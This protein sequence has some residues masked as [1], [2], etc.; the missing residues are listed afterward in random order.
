[1]K[2]LPL[3]A[4][5]VFLS[6]CAA[7]RVSRHAVEGA[8]AVEAATIHVVRA[9]AAGERAKQSIATGQQAVSELKLTAT[10]K[11]MP[12]VLTVERSLIDTAREKEAILSA[13]SDIEPELALARVSIDKLGAKLLKAEHDARN[14]RKMKAWLSL[15]AA[16]GGAYMA[17]RMVPAVSGPVRYYAAAGVSLV[18]GFGLYFFVL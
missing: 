18:I 2:T 10:A 13:L 1:M 8:K 7:P 15:F 16:L 9:K 3:I 12:H 6:G 5:A 11:Q 4:V 14:Y 17:F